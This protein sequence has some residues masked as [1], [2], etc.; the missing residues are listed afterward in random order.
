[1]SDNVTDQRKTEIAE[2]TQ[3]MSSKSGRNTM[4]RMLQFTGVDENMFNPDTHE[5]AR[6][7]GRREVGLWLRDELKGSCFSEY[8]IMLK[9]NE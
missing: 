7:A 9:E 3:V 6:N 5:H 4:Y 1:M 2:I 8:L